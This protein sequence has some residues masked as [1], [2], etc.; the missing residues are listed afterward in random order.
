MRTGRWPWRLVAFTAVV[1][2]TCWLVYATA[3]APWPPLQDI[4]LDIIRLDGFV[5]CGREGWGWAQLA[6]PAIVL[7]VEVG[8]CVRVWRGGTRAV[9]WPTAVGVGVLLAGYVTWLVIRDH[10]NC[11]SI[12]IF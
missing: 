1:V 7:L 9:R 2:A 8:L 4:G 12:T 10:G 6:V 3:W 11:L 5:G